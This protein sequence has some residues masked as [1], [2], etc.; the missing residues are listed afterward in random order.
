MEKLASRLMNLTESQTFAMSERSADLKKKGIDVVNLTIGEP[1]FNTPDEVK[2][3]AK[4]AIDKNIT[5]YPPVAGFYE[6]RE[7][8]A[9]KFRSICL[10]MG[11]GGAVEHQRFKIIMINISSYMLRTILVVQALKAF[12]VEI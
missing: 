1:D 11:I 3:A 8:I 7:A 2:E 9:E 5:K 4:E 10:S 12:G 6:L